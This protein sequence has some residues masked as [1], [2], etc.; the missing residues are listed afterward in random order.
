MSVG[1]SGARGTTMGRGA[2]IGR[3]GAGGAGN[4]FVAAAVESG[5]GMIAGVRRITGNTVPAGGV[6]AA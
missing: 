2:M 5:G 4:D 6:G 1:L 3:G